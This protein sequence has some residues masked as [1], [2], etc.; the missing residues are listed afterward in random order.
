QTW[1]VVSGAAPWAARSGHALVS[2]QGRLLL[3]GG[4]ASNL[5]DPDVDEVLRRDVWGSTDGSAWQQLSGGAP[6]A[7][8]ERLG[9]AVCRG[10]MA[11]VVGGRGEAGNLGD[12][13]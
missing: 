4:A 5:L 11:L 8:R 13:W 9:A 1:E 6:F 7:G 12:V 2:L 3:V 10:Q